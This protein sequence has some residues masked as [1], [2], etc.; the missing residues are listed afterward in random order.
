MGKPELKSTFQLW[1]YNR[2]LGAWE[3]S[4]F[5][6]DLPEAKVARR[7]IIGETPINVDPDFKIVQLRDVT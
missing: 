3:C 1:T 7:E 6:D 4:G 2:T 5:F